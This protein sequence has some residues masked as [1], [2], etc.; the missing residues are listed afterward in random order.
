MP[1]LS[2]LKEALMAV[3][4]GKAEAQKPAQKSRLTKELERALASQKTPG[5]GY[6]VSFSDDLDDSQP[7]PVFEENSDFDES[8]G[9]CT[10]EG[11]PPPNAPPIPPARRSKARR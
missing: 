4:G 6:A 10:V 7:M 1:R 3:L 5:Y 8:S 2:E 11:V 9:V